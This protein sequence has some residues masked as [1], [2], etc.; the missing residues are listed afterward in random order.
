MVFINMEVS[1]ILHIICGVSY[2]SHDCFM[3]RTKSF[4]T[5][6]ARTYDTSCIVC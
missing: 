3:F 6:R 4:A 5:H 2:C 1:P